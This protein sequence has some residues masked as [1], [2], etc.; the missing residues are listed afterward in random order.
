MPV[1][2]IENKSLRWLLAELMVVV[3]GILI[4]FQVDEWRT[5]RLEGQA[6]EVALRGILEEFA[7]NLENI[8]AA[9]RVVEKRLM[10]A[11]QVLSLTGPDFDKAEAQNAIALLAELINIR[12][13][14]QP[15]EG[16]LSNLIN[17]EGL[18]TISSAELR[19]HLINWPTYTARTDDRQERLRELLRVYL[20]PYLH[21][22]VPVRTLDASANIDQGLDQAE[23]R[24]SLE[25]ESVFTD[26][27]FENIVYEVFFADTVL[28]DA[29]VNAEAEIRAIISL[30]ES[31]VS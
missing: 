8:T 14:F 17:G 20:M 2:G 22:R 6:E 13:N 23:S 27:N 12:F 15:A 29:L 16:T 1:I 31:Q 18:G 26:L 21:A 28:L 24:F 9:K 25:I 4:A 11:N 3:L 10:L 30:V 7:T 5:E 19:Q